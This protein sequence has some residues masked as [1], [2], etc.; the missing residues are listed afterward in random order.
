M[1]TRRT[2]AIWRQITARLAHP[3]GQN[4]DGPRPRLCSTIGTHDDRDG[5]C[6][7]CGKTLRPGDPVCADR[8]GGPRVAP[9]Q[10]ATP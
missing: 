8:P 5:R 6:V 1:N 7:D 3:A 4:L 2:D 10:E 9:D